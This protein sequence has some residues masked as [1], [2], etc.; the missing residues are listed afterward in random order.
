M[1]PEE[2]RRLGHEL[3]DWIA[4]VRSRVAAGE[5]PVMSQVAPGWLRERLPAAPPERG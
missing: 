4:D 3:V 1:T 5:P 2:F